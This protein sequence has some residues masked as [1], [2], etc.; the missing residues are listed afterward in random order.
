MPRATR[1]GPSPAIAAA[2]LLALALAGGCADRGS[3]LLEP[4]PPLPAATLALVQAR[5]FDP[6][7]TGC[8]FA[9][10]AGGLDLTSGSSH[11]QLVG[12]D[13]QTVAGWKRVVAGEPDASLLYRKVLADPQAGPAMP[14][15]AALL[16]SSLVSLLRRWIAA[17]ASSGP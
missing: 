9:G 1:P 4:P 3:P 8:H 10:G 2:V 7:C 11:A 13:A 17:G 6:H 12:V 14:F 16:D 15:G 5:V